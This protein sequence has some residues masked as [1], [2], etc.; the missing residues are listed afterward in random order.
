M[1]L[2]LRKLS[3]LRNRITS[4]V[5][6]SFS[7]SNI[8]QQTSNPAKNYFNVAN[9]MIPHKDRVKKLGE[10]AYYSSSKIM[11]VADGVGGWAW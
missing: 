8:S 1:N 4:P 5:A 10:D 9:Y 11:S 6:K 2:G 3:T 7:E